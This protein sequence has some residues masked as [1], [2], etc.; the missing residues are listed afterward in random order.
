MKVLN[1]ILYIALFFT[2]VGE[3]IPF[4][5]N[6]PYIYI[7]V[8]GLIAVICMIKSFACFKYKYKKEGIIFFIL[9]LAYIVIIVV[10]LAVL[11]IIKIF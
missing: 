7:G 9:S 4:I 8:C 6:I 11:G 5:A 2:F 10:R 3:S 1:I